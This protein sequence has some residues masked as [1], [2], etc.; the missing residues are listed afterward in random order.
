MSFTYGYVVFKG[1]TLQGICVG[2]VVL[3]VIFVFINMSV[4]TAV[5]LKGSGRVP[6]R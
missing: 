1:D 2:D 4:G 6:Y 3:D 5:F